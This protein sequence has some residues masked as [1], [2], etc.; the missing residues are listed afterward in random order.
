M[1]QPPLIRDGRGA[2]IAI[3]DSGVDPSHPWLA[4]AAL[5]HYQLVQEGSGWQVVA[6][7]GGDVSGHGTAC[8]G[9]LH[10]M[11]PAAALVSIK[12]LG[13]DGRC[14]RAA[15][16]AALRHCIRERFHVVNLSLGIAVPRKAALKASDHQPILSLYEL[17]DA[18]YT[19]GVV[20]VASG[21]NVETFRTYPG[22]AKALI[23]VGR[24]SFEDMEALASERGPDYEILAPGTDVLAPALGGGERRW[25]GTSFACPFV[26]AHVARI[27]AARPGLPI[28]QVKAALHALAAGP[29]D[30]AP[31]HE[32]AS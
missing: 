3:V 16:L 23:G 29:R 4:G 25:T 9:I 8:A 20:L 10:R 19:V 22:R 5:S 13:A 7:A 32:E 11:V 24:G 27:V 15:L 28:E 2:R 1:S 6:D 14:S 18:A 17:A 30:D 26:S 12:A 21:P 31:R